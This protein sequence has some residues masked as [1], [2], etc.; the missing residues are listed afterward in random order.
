MTLTEIINT[1][2]TS[3]RTSFGST[4]IKTEYPSEKTQLPSMYIRL[5]SSNS[6]PY[7]VGSDILKIEQKDVSMLVVVFEKKV[8]QA[9]DITSFKSELEQI[10]SQLDLLDQW[11]LD[12]RS[13]LTDITNM[14]FNVETNLLYDPNLMA[15]MK[16]A[17]IG[18]EYQHTWT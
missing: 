4:Y 10:D 6:V 2:L 15:Y 9:S 1:V 13:S 7:V 16:N 5:T 18:I 8:I 17:I 12:N 14:D 11:R 3:L